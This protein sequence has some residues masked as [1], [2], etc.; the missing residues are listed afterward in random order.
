[1]Q[2]VLDGATEGVVYVSLGSNIRSVDLDARLRK[3]IVEALSELPYKVLWKWESDCLLDR[4]KN[5]VTRKWYP[6]QDILGLGLW[7]FCNGLTEGL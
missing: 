5:V 3:V 1:M 7:L 4:P 2:K 6:Q